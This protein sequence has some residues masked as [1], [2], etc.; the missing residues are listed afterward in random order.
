M[1]TAHH[2]ARVHA[3]KNDCIC[4]FLT[5]KEPGETGDRTAL[6]PSAAGLRATSTPASGWEES[7][8]AEVRKRYYPAVADKSRDI[9]RRCAAAAL[10]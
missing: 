7:D 3:S 6:E 9:R 2:P 1:A 8:V 5:K 4:A 10:P